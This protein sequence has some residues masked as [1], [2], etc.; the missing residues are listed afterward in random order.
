MYR[1]RVELVLEDFTEMA[2]AIEALTEAVQQPDS[3][4]YH[5]MIKSS[6]SKSEAQIRV[7]EFDEHTYRHPAPQEPEEETTLH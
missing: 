1:V 2:S 3:L 5:N 7:E 4:P 6:D